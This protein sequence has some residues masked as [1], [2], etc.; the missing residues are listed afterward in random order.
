MDTVDCAKAIGL[1]AVWL[2]AACQFETGPLSL[3]GDLAPAATRNG[4]AE[5]GSPFDNPD[6]GATGASPGSQNAGAPATAQ[7]DGSIPVA[8]SSGNAGSAPSDP[9]PNTPDPDPGPDAGPDAIDAAPGPDA[10]G[11]DA[12]PID[13]GDAGAP[14][15]PEPGTVFSACS[16]NADCNLGL[17]CITSLAALSGTPLTAGYCAALCNWTGAAA[18]PCPQ[19]ATG[20]VKTACQPGVNVCLLG[21]CERSLC[22]LEMHCSQIDTPL[23]AGQVRTDFVC[24]P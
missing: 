20:L 14:S 17:V 4:A 7:S 15:G 18:D 16:A 10:A 11:P 23:G 6:M 1:A 24:Q 5:P 9:V 22:P 13:P 2:C 21:D 19:P 3:Q 12:A 8:G